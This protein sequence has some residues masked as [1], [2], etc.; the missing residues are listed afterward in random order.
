MKISM[1]VIMSINIAITINIVIALYLVVGVGMMGSKY[2][3]KE[4]GLIL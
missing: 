1:G 4:S 2:P 3:N